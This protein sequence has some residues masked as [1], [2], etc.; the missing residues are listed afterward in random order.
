MKSWKYAVDRSAETPGTG[1]QTGNL[2]TL[3]TSARAT[4]WRTLQRAASA[5]VPRLGWFPLAIALLVAAALAAAPQSAPP[6]QIQR[7]VAQLDLTAEQKSKIDPILEEDAKQVRAL[8]GDT[9]PEAANKKAEIRKATD[10]KI[11]PLLTDAQWKKLE[12]LRADRNQQD[13]KKK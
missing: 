5:L 10:A 9:S 12:Q 1:P 3:G 6:S 8:R 4:L 13:R 7:M 2:G 11:K